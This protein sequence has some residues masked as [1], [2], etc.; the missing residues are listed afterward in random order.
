MIGVA[1]EVVTEAV[2][3]EMTVVEEIEDAAVAT[4]VVE[5]ED[6]SDQDQ[7]KKCIV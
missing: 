2:I 4:F 5:E 3:D 6:N 1:T 7:S